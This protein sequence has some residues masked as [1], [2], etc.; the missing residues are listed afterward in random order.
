MKVYII[1]EGQ[2]NSGHEFS[3]KCVCASGTLAEHIKKAFPYYSLV[4]TE[5][6]VIQ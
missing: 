5:F 6:E 2:P 1:T 4:I 3:I